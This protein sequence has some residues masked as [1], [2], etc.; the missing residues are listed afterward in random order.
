LIH[1]PIHD[2]ED[3]KETVYGGV[4]YGLMFYVNHHCTSPVGYPLHNK[5]NPFRKHKRMA[6]PLTIMEWWE[7]DFLFRR[8]EEIVVS[9]ND[10]AE[11]DIKAE[12]ILTLDTCPTVC[13]LR[14]HYRGISL[15]RA[16]DHPYYR[17]SLH[18]EDWQRGIS[19][20]IQVDFIKSASHLGDISTAQLLPLA[21]W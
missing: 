10:E 16:K 7:G 4:V 13:S 20:H 1:I 12:Y 14:Q 2:E 8:E 17:L 9:Y 6:L 3:G 19:A 18:S 11:L 21:F 5:D 15:S